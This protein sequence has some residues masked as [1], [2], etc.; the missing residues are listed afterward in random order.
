MFF[1]VAV[2]VGDQGGEVTVTVHQFSAERFFKQASC[3]L[4]GFVECFCTGAEKVGEGPAWIGM[5]IGLPVLKG[6]A[7]LLALFVISDPH[8]QMKMVAHQTMGIR[9]SNWLNVVRLQFQEIRIV[10]L[11]PEQRFAVVAAVVDMIVLAVL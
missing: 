9:F 8:Q 7:D 4:V 3:S 1:W 5:A 10:A 11:F 6:L 2:D